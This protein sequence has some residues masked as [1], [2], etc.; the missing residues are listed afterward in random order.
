MF[1]AWF[2]ELAVYIGLVMIGG[3]VVAFLVLL[4]RDTRSQ[5]LW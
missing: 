2:L 4:Y 1:P 3:S 5:T